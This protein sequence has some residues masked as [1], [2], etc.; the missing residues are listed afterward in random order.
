MDGEWVYRLAPLTTPTKP[1]ATAALALRYPAVRLFVDRAQL[2]NPQFVLLDDDAPAV[3]DLC[4]KLDGNPLAIELAAGRLSMFG[5]KGLVNGLGET[6]SLLSQGRR[7]ALPRQQTL[8]ATLDWSFTLLNEAEKA[9]LCRL[10]VFRG[11][12]TL[13]QAISV[14]AD[15]GAE[16]LA[17]EAI[18]ELTAK[19]LI[20]VDNARTPRRYRLLFLTRSYAADKLGEGSEFKRYPFILLNLAFSLQSAYAAPLILLAQTRQADRDKCQAEADA[21]HRE[22]LAQ[23]ND[24]R[25]EL[26]AQQTAMLLEMLQQNTQLTETVKELTERVAALTTE[27]HNQLVPKTA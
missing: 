22:D 3:C 12:F 27:V 18:A 25:Q 5:I 19:S 6:L 8:R 15:E 9:A 21:R 20:Q 24:A 13:P 16:E 4:R 11:E 10:S 17:V 14:I 23:A 26:A 1:S 2:A 7:T